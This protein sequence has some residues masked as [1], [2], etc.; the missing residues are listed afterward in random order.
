[1]PKVGW[2]LEQRKA[3]KRWMLFAAL[4]AVAGVVLSAFLI[5]TGN[6]G[7]WVVLVMTLCIFGAVYLFVGNAKNRQ[8]R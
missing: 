8:P 5:V 2:S 1:M 3:V 4:F 6:S 7:G